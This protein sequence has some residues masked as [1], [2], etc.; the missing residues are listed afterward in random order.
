[1]QQTLSEFLS[2]AW[3]E[4]A[5]AAQAVVD[6]LPQAF[7]LLTHEPT[8]AA[9]LARLAEHV[10]LAH[11]DHGDVLRMQLE[12]LHPLAEQ[13]PALALALRR[14]ELALALID[15]SA[16]SGLADLGREL[17]AA[18]QVRAHGQAV[19]ALTRRADWPAIYA[20]IER[21]TPI[22]Q[23]DDDGKALRALAVLSNNLAGDLRYYR[24]SGATGQGERD[25]LMLEAARLARVYWERAGGWVEVERAD[26]QLAMC[27]AAAEQGEAALVAAQACLSRCLDNS[28]DAYELFFAHE[29]MAYAHLAASQVGEARQQR[30]LMQELLAGVSDQSAQEYALTCLKKLEA[31]LS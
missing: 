25:A 28:A 14:S 21:A 27:H 2:Q 15:G 23:S 26:Y 22:A 3:D 6:R 17:P 16:G 8:A 13:D 29:A 1:M 20:L 12:R 10:L 31:Q 30:A 9:E 11:L 5:D 18:E 4:H 7:E 24:Q 19:L